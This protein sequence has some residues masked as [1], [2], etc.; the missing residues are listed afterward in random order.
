MS[1]ELSPDI[2]RKSLSVALATVT[3]LSN[4]LFF[5]P[6][7]AEDAPSGEDAG[8]ETLWAYEENYLKNVKDVCKV[9]WNPENGSILQAKDIK[10]PQIGSKTAEKEYREGVRSVGGDSSRLEEL[11]APDIPSAGEGFQMGFPPKFGSD[12]SRASEVYKERMNGIFAC[13][14]INYKIR[15][16]EQLLKT[17][18][19]EKADSGNTVKKIEEQTRM[20]RQELSKRKCADRT[21]T[22]GKSNVLMKK[23]LLRQ[24]TYEYCNYRHYLQYLKSNAQYRLA[25]FIDAE[26]KRKGATANAENAPSPSGPVEKLAESV[27]GIV[28]RIDQEISHTREVFPQSMVAYTEFE[29]TY[30]S[31]V[32]MLFILE[33]YALLRDSLKKVMNPL[34]Q[35]IFKASNAQSPFSP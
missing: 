33:D 1:I 30:A 7:F 27:G 2:F 32:V 3:V 10:Y 20:L 16:H 17:V 11:L 21:A 5:V 19:G 18:K 23:D 14:Q 29:R 35:V 4:S 24:S 25:N 9:Q 15:V 13:A 8:N 6:V 28:V 34:G 31:H 12:V 22:E 26:E